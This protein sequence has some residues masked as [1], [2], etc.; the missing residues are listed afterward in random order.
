MMEASA[1]SDWT[2]ED[3]RERARQYL[4]CNPHLEQA[5]IRAWRVVE[6]AINDECARVRPRMRVFEAHHLKEIT[7]AAFMKAMIEG[8]DSAT[9]VTI[10]FLA[11]PLM[12]N[13]EERA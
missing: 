12:A 7:R 6:E 13:R 1:K 3:I 4:C 2:P 9:C 8:K 11:T 5:F 10:A